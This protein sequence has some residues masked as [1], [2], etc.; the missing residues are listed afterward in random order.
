MAGRIVEAFVSNACLSASAVIDRRYIGRL[1][2]EMAIEV[3]R[4]YLFRRH[5][6]LKVAQVSNLRSN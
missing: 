1:R 5:R 6:A 2:R 3:N 4:R